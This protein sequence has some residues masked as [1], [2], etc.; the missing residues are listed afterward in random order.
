K[1]Y[2]ETKQK[3]ILFNN[4]AG[5]QLPNVILNK[6]NLSKA[7]TKTEAD[8]TQYQDESFDNKEHFKSSYSYRQ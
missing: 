2:I 5:F 4:R 7:N 1:Y 8:L 3:V 6:D